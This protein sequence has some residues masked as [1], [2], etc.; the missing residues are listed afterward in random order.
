VSRVPRIAVL[1]AASAALG[2]AAHA[3]DV[4]YDPSIEVGVQYNDN[5]TLERR[6]GNVR[7]VSGAFAEAGL[8]VRGEA[9]R[10]NW[11]L[12]PRI[13]SNYFPD[14]SDLKSTDYIFLAA[15][16]R[17]NE[18]NA[19]GLT[20]DY[21]DQDIVQSQLPDANF[22]D[23]DL[24]EGSGPDSGRIV[25]ENRQKLLRANPY[26]TFK[27]SELTDLRV[28]LS[29]LDVS[30][31]REIVNAQ[32]SYQ[33]VGGR[34]LL[35]RQFT[36]ASRFGLRLEYEQVEPDGS[37]STSDLAGAQLQWDYRIAERLSAYGRLGVKRSDFEV[38]G[39]GTIRTSLQETTPL[40][41]AGMR[42][43]F[44]K[45][46]LFVDLQ[47]VVDANA[48]GFVVE[49]DDLRAF[50]NHRF[51]VRLLGYVGGYLIRDESVTSGGTYVPRRYYTALAGLEWRVLRALAVRGEVGHS[52]QEYVGE[53]G[54]AD[55]NSARVSVVYRPRRVD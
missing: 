9:P 20:A 5:Y 36:P 6:S 38:V 18:R 11:R 49:R 8:L 53:S 41:A 33:S 43:S 26:A 25:G 30:F 14:D 19:F 55:G 10:S 50:Y 29:G 34:L 44:L 12:E 2:A 21:Y 13:R 3:A 1:A 7:D 24:G 52:S 46:E 17:R 37:S 40:F 42:W 39:P 48:S 15:A 47:R 32:V 31:D 23:S 27:L 35:D 22:G 4:Q 45:S 16:E 28:E 54:A 51:S